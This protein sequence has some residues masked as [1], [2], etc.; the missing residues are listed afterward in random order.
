MNKNDR[1][2]SLVA[3]SVNDKGLKISSSRPHAIKSGGKLERKMKEIEAHA[4][5]HGLDGH[6][7]EVTDVACENAAAADRART[8]GHFFEELAK[9]TRASVLTRIPTKTTS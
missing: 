9:L 2:A 1:I 7:S 4:W 3:N 8:D 6:D 5:L